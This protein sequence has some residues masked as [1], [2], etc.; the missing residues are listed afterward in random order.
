MKKIEN[1]AVVCLLLALALG[2]VLGLALPAGAMEVVVTLNYIL[3]QLVSFC[4]PLIVI[5]F[6]APSITKMGSNAT[7]M[8]MVAIIVAYASTVLATL[9]SMN[10]GYVLVPF[11]PIASS[12]EGLKELPGVAFQ[13][14]IPQIMPVMSALVF[15]VIYKG[16]SLLREQVGSYL[17]VNEQFSTALRRLQG[18]LLT[19][20]QPIY[21]MVVPALTTLVNALTHAIAVLAQFFAGLFGTTAKKAQTQ[22][23]RSDDNFEL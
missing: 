9:M 13:L 20:F 2:V 12:M 5:G 22:Q 7:R 23:G 6:I 1:R 21:D 19:A 4:V 18:V 3:G 10:A 11:L 16:L 15:S 14:D 17:M 8:L